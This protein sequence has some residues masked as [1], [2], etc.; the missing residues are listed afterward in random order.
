MNCRT[1]LS[2]SLF[3]SLALTSFLTSAASPQAATSSIE[4]IIVKI[5]AADVRLRF[6]DQ[7]GRVDDQA[8]TVGGGTPIEGATVELTGIVGTDVRSWLARSGRDGKFVIRNLP[9]GQGYQLLVIRSPEYLPA[10]YAQPAPGLPGRP[11]TLS[12]GQNLNTVRIALWPAAQVSG[13]VLDRKGKGVKAIVT[14][15]KPWYMETW[16]VLAQTQEQSKTGVVARVETNDRGEYRFQ[17]LPAGQYYF[18]ARSTSNIQVGDVRGY[19]FS[20]YYGASGPSDEADP[21]DLSLGET[22]SNLNIVGE[23]QLRTIIQGQAIDRRTGNLV[24]PTQAHIVRRGELPEALTEVA[25]RPTSY[26]GPTGFVISLYPGDYVMTLLGRGTSATVKLDVGNASGANLRIP[27]SPLTEIDGRVSID[28]NPG[29][30]FAANGAPVKVILRSLTAPI[31]NVVARVLP[32]GT[33]H[34]REIPAGDYR[35]DVHPF[36][37]APPEENVPP[38]LRDFYVRSLRLGRDDVL[39]DGLRIEGSFANRMEVV[40]GTNGGVVTGRILR[41]KKVAVVNARAVLI[42]NSARRRFDLYKTAFTDDHGQFEI[43]G[44]APGDYKVFS[45]ELV[46]FGA[47]QD[48][49]FLKLYENRGTPVRISAGG[50][51]SVDGVLIPALDIQDLK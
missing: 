6:P 10:Q 9:P 13:R 40:V 12:S 30:V 38:S 2:F 23:P 43:R 37:S 45:W 25:T 16:R 1:T 15:F 3:F 35:V 41:D 51:Q 27:L 4:G 8:V 29:G 39:A 42:P 18:H 44:V 5:G 17:G 50:R 47:W 26:A 11:L 33:F 21:V 24:R 19:T 28:G 49:Q 32:D 36:L 20:S 22:V 34:L 31:P 7:D 48:P 46:E 14:A